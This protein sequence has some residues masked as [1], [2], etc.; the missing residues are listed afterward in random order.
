MRV[1]LPLI[2]LFAV[3]RCGYEPTRKITDGSEADH[4]QSCD[5]DE[6]RLTSMPMI[7]NNRNS[8][9]AFQVGKSPRHRSTSELV[10]QLQD[11]L[12]APSERKPR[13]SSQKTKVS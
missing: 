1:P 6:W 8:R 9:L 7:F 2:E 3:R 12:K 5:D 13:S 11:Q 4:E 10:D